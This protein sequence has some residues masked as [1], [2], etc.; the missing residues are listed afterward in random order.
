MSGRGA[1][2]ERERGR[3]RIWNWLQALSCQHGSQGRAR[4]HKPRDHDPSWSW[5]LNW[6][7]HRGVHIY[8][9][10]VTQN[11]IFFLICSC[12]FCTVPTWW[13][14][15]V[16]GDEEM[17]SCNQSPPTLS[18]RTKGSVLPRHTLSRVL[19]HSLMARTINVVI[20][21]LPSVNLSENSGAENIL[22]FHKNRH[23]FLNQIVSIGV[24]LK[25]CNYQSE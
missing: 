21:G 8:F 18:L 15:G 1:E 17:L 7:S 3:H 24:Y 9:F 13:K 16:N 23:V 10:L 6:L 2:R 14:W 5:T 19:P 20:V 25:T 22:L 12:T 4:T 11:W